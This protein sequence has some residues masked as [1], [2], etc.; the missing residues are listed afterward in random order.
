[1]VAALLMVYLFVN[2]WSV[3]QMVDDVIAPAFDRIG[4]GWESGLIDVYQERRACEVCSSALRTI[5][6]M[7]PEVPEHAPKAIGGSIENDPYALPTLAVEVTLAAH[8]WNAR[9]FGSNI[10]FR[11]FHEAVAAEQPESRLAEHF[12]HP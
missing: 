1:M 11:S 10:P 2:L 3:E 6:S 12:P 4:R 8:G 5:R 7:L 9:S